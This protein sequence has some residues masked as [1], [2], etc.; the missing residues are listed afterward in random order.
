MGIFRLWRHHLANAAH[1]RYLEL[2][3]SVRQRERAEQRALARQHGPMLGTRCRDEAE[4]S[5]YVNT[6]L[7]NCR[8]YRA[9]ALDL[10]E[11]RLRE[12]K[13]RTEFDR[14]TIIRSRL[15]G[16]ITWTALREYVQTVPHAPAMRPPE[17]LERILLHQDVGL[18]MDGRPT[19]DR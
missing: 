2:H 15:E 16:P 18:F 12:A 11:T 1:R 8:I 9:V 17:H 19:T 4:W 14:W 13:D 10:A 7:L 3:P 5:A 6:H